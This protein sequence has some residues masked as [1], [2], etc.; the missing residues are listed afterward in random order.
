[1]KLYK[2]LPT[3]V[4]YKGTEYQFN[5]WFHVILYCN[6]IMNDKQLSDEE[7][8]LWCFD[9]LVDVRNKPLSLMDKNQIV[10]IIFRTLFEKPKQ[11]SDKQKIFD[12]EQDAKYIYAAFMQ[13]YN[14]DL[15]DVKKLH[16]WKFISLFNGLPQDTKIMQI[17]D[18]R[19]KPI[20]KR[21]KFNGEYITSLMKLK[22]EY[23]LEISQEEQE[24]QMQD[25]L[26]NLF[27][28]LKAQAE[29]R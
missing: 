10:L 1:M 14:I 3:T 26:G 22:A 6:D 27:N 15:L 13:A 4:E 29:K 9:A 28:K 12:F 8:I 16:W 2:K 11:S 23:K 21:T 20:P 5:P 24:K 7:K 17:I 25:F 19:T 18:I